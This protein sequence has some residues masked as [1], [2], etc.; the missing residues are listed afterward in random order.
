MNI[1]VTVLW[2][3][4]NTA[5]ILHFISVTGKDFVE[6]VAFKIANIVSNTINM[7]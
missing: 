2:G 3:F 4:V 7:I 5:K 6:C 1:V